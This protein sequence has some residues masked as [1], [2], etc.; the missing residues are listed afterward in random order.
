MSDRTIVI[1]SADGNYLAANLSNVKIIVSNSRD[2]RFPRNRMV[3]LQA[4]RGQWLCSNPYQSGLLDATSPNRSGWETFELRDLG[5]NQAALRASTGKFVTAK[6]NGSQLVADSS[7]VGLDQIFT[8]NYLSS[9]RVNL[10]CNNGFYVCA[11]DGGGSYVVNN[12]TAPD[13]WETFLLT[14]LPLP[15]M[16]DR[17]V[18]LRTFNGTHVVCA[19]NGGAAALTAN[20]TAVRS[21]ETFTLKDLGQGRIALVACNGKYVRIDDTGSQ[22]LADQTVTGP[23][24]T[25]YLRPLGS[26]SYALLAGNGSYVCAEGG[27]GQGLVCRSSRV[28]GWE[29]FTILFFYTPRDGSVITLKG[30]N[31]LYLSRYWSLGANEIRPCKSEIDI[32]SMFTVAVRDGKIALRADNGLWVSRYNHGDY[33]TIEA[34]KSEIDVHCLFA[35]EL[36]GNVIALLA[37]NGRYV[38]R[39]SVGFERMQPD[40]TALDRK[41]LLSVNA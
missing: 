36:Q 21:W 34:C 14:T 8:I 38:G 6:S 16:P 35:V 19:E 7:T 40:K 37:D 5:S 15:T 23:M 41:C 28:G 31:G 9:G 26:G 32:Y 20:R 2:S 1:D 4:A 39:A 18:A 33:Q 3:G 10:R 12:R 24:S 11:N 17:L 22:L 29:M 13:I 27:G 25:F 30:D